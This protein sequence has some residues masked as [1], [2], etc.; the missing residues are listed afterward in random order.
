MLG[1]GQMSLRSA[2]DATLE[3][4]TFI[5]WTLGALMRLQ[6]GYP[7]Q[8]GIIPWTLGA[9]FV[10]SWGAKPGYPVDPWGTY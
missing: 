10:D 8:C 2:S 9:H 6:S 1:N 7:H 3:L 4:S 5:P